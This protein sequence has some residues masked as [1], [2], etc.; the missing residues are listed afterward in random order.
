M[1][2]LDRMSPAARKVLEDAGIATEQV[3]QAVLDLVAAAPPL[4]DDAV[5]LLR[6]AGCPTLRP[7]TQRAAS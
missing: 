7:S 2:A 3:A 4:P 1:S 6:A 5:E